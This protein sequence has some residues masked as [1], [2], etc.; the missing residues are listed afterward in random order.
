MKKLCACAAMLAVTAGSAAAVDSE[1]GPYT[2]DTDTHDAFDC[3]GE[4]KW[5]QM[6]NGASGLSSQDDACYPFTSEVADDFMGDG[7]TMVGVGWYGVYWNG[8]PIAPDSFNIHVYADDAGAPGELIY[9]HNT[10]E[11]NETVG[12]PYG[13]CTQVEPFDKED[14][15]Q[16]WLGIQSVFCFPP[17]WG[18]ATGDGNGVSSYQLFPLLGID[19]WEPTGFDQAFL[20]YNEGAPTPTEDAT[21]SA[22]KGL[23]R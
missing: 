6:P 12:D 1:S 7:E 2:V 18:W 8:T 17:Q 15:V 9:T 13:Y 22:I 20:L 21:W 4:I 14:G 19:P 11:Y 23:Y 16:Y 3:E 5:E 10:T